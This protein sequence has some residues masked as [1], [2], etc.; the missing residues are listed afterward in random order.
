MKDVASYR[1]RAL[2]VLK[3]IKNLATK[4][5]LNISGIIE[6]EINMLRLKKN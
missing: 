6:E 5:N 1:F 4:K 3:L 2:E